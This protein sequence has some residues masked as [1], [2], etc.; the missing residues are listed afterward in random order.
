MDLPFQSLNYDRVFTM[1]AIICA[2]VTSPYPKAYCTDRLCLIY[3]FI[4]CILNCRDHSPFS[5]GLETF[6]HDSN[7][8]A[9]N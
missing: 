6:F 5:L 2:E 7:L 1:E 4:G 9:S 3:C 8:S